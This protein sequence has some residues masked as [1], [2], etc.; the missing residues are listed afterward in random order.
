MLSKKE[1]SKL[2]NT[3]FRHLD[4]LTVCPIAYTLFQHKVTDYIL[5]QKKVDLTTITKAFNANEG[6]LNVGLRALCSQGWLNQT[7]NNDEDKVTFEINEHTEQAFSHF[8]LYKE[9]NQ[10]LK[11]SEHY[12]PRK[13]EM[14]PFLKLEQVFN[15]FKEEFNPQNN[16]EDSIRSQIIAHI[17]GVILGPTLVMLGM[18]GMF[19]KYFMETR[20]RPEEFHANVEGFGRLLEILAH[21]GW[22]RPINESYQF[23][24]KGLFFAKRASAY[25]VTVSYIPTLRKFDELMFGNPTVLKNKDKLAKELHVDREMNVWGSGGAHAAYFKVVDQIIISIFNKPIDQ[26]PKGILDMGCGNG[27]FL[28][29]LYYVIENQTYR[30]TVLDEY[31]LMLIGVDYN[32]AALKVSRANLIQADIWA[33][34]IWGDI[35]NPDLLAKDLEEKYAIKLGELLNVRTFLD[36]NRIWQEPD[37]NDHIG[38]SSST[39]AYAFEGERK[40]NNKVYRSLVQHFKKW[41]PYVKRHGLLLIELH[42]VAPDLV[43]QNIGKTAATAYDVTHGFSDQYILELD[44]YMSAMEEA[45]LTAAPEYFRKFPNADIATVSINL[46]Q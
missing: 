42:T 24:E 22:F 40:N 19:H 43:A 13:F 12:H 35:G 46:F 32:E 30:G 9:A 26:Q 45:G 44:E 20:F 31:P 39:G 10:L 23:T 11:I 28:I 6:Y 3:L 29:H 18:S 38:A 37:G 34:I 17:E 16:D 25:G 36:H 27:A 4:G 41:M 14:E 2:R 7:V 8:E 5:T 33:K 1:L 21:F 15:T